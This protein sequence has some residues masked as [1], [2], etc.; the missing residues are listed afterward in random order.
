MASPALDSPGGGVQRT[1]PAVW[2]APLLD[3]SGYADEARNFLLSL[4]RSGYQVAARNVQL[5]GFN[6]GLSGVSAQVV[7]RALARDA[8]EGD[9][10][11]VRHM[12][13]T[14]T[15]HPYPERGP[16]VMR[17]MFETDRIPHHWRP[18]LLDVDEIWLPCPHN[19]EAFQRSG[20]PAERLRLLPGTIDFEHFDPA[21]RISPTSPAASR[22]SR[23]STSP[24]AKAGTSCSMPG[25]RPSNP[26]TTSRWSSSASRCT[27]ARTRSEPVSMPISTGAR[28]RR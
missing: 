11:F 28:R 18:W 25:P 22:S 13:P 2:L 9:F 23:T 12:Q 7:E 1:L 16:A 21:S 4:E 17:T 14:P 10:A 19:I 20:I 24:I 3:P 27:A 5:S 8:P 6:G 26:A 15:E